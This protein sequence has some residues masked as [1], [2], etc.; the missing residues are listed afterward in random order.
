V[1]TT[2]VVD[3]PLVDEEV[4]RHRRACDGFSSVAQAAAPDSWSVPTPCTE[5]TARDVVE[6]VIGFHEFLLLRPLGVRARRP[7]DDPAARWSATSLTLFTALTTEGVLDRATELPGGGESTPRTMLGALTTDVLVH[8]W[9]LAR[10]VGLP[11]DLDDELCI[12]AYEAA[13]ASEFRRADGMIGEEIPVAA[14]ASATDKL[15][16]LYGRD[17]GW[18]P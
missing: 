14:G 13:Y 8:T 5:W 11:S 17:P 3:D 9:D 16:A 15:V 4:V 12:R 2:R 1:P 7:R 18:E 10:A 6:H